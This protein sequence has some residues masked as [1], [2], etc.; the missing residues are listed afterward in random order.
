MKL[1][2]LLTTLPLLLFAVYYRHDRA[3]IDPYL[4]GDTFRAFSDHAYDEVT[5]FIPQLVKEGQTIFV[6][7]DKIAE[8]FSKY[9]PQ[10]RSRYI[11]ITHNSDRSIPGE[12]SKYLDD[13][14]II[15]WFTQNPDGTNHPKLHPLP[16]GLENRYWKPDNVEIITRVKEKHLP[17]IHLLYCNFSTTSYVPERPFVHELLSTAP[18]TY[19]Q[20][21]KN[22]ESFIEEIASSKFVL[23]PRGN[24]LDTHRLWETLYSGSY[25]IVKTS[26]LDFLYADLPVVIVSEWTEITEEFLHRKYEELEKKRYNFEKLYTDFWFRWINSYKMEF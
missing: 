14:H 11:L 10:I 19:T 12:S 2:Y 6:N 26:S 18:F 16:I 8:F 20:I 25:P 23:S 15:A 13:E 5:R 7:G 1:L 3:P 21:R 17:K 24:G 9:H 22:Y 4:S